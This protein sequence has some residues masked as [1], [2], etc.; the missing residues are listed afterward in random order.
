MGI[1]GA[2]ALVSCIVPAFNSEAHLEEAVT[3]IL[4]QSYRPVDVVVADDG[5][6]DRTVVIARG[7]GEVVRVVVQ[8]TAGPAATRNLGIREARGDFVAFLDPDDLWLPRKLEL[9]MKRFA[10]RPALQCSVT[11]AQ[12]FWDDSC[13]D[14]QKRYHGHARMRPVPGYALTTLLARRASF[15]DVGL[16]DESLWYADAVDWFVRAYDQGVDIELIPD[17]LT[18]HRLH[19]ANLTRRRAEASADEFLTLVKR[20]LDRRRGAVQ[21]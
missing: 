5:S 18:R 17:V 21:A 13:P 1:A 7:L 19:G 10:A 20:R 14:E 2:N 16:L 12:A 9:Q 4:A 3:S 8:P 6:S 11:F 15:D